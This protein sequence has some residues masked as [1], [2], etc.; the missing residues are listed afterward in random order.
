MKMKPFNNKNSD[1][2]TLIEVIA[3]MVILGIMAATLSLVIMEG[4]GNFIFARDANQLSQKAQLALA[5]INKELIDATV[6]TPD[7]TGKKIDYTAASDKTSY[8]IEIKNTQIQLNGNA[9]LDNVNTDNT[10]FSYFKSDGST[11]TTAD[12]F[13]KL[14]QIKVNLTLNYGSGQALVFKTT[15][16][17]RNNTTRN[18]PKLY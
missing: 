6:I 10:L 11:W 3:V 9:L 5:R 14:V 18:T 2:F 1:G 7:A 17:P 13:S 4:V 8:T 12:A 15:I 16:N